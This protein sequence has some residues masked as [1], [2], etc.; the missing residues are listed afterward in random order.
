MQPTPGDFTDARFTEAPMPARA[1]TAP[2]DLSRVE[3]EAIVY[4]GDRLAMDRPVRRGPE[5]ADA[6]RLDEPAARRVLQRLEDLG[7]LYAVDEPAPRRVVAR[8]DVPALDEDPARPSAEG[9]RR[10]L[11][12]GVYHELLRRWTSGYQV[13]DT[14]LPGLDGQPLAADTRRTVLARLR[15]P[16]RPGGPLLWPY[17]ALVLTPEGEAARGALLRRR[18]GA[19][20][21]GSPRAAR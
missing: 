15:D 3:V 13:R 12:L 4:I 10:D 16:A 7:L 5:L 6:L 20:D 14:W 8:E 19:G 21:V 18:P 1:T 17:G 11:E 9:R 2:I